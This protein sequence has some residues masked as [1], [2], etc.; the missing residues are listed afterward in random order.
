MINKPRSDSAA[1]MV[2]RLR[3]LTR[4]NVARTA[5]LE[6]SFEER[7]RIFD[8]LSDCVFV[9]AGG[10]FLL[11]NREGT[12]VLESVGNPKGIL[13]DLRNA[14]PGPTPALSDWTRAIDRRGDPLVLRVRSTLPIR[15]R[16][17]AGRVVV[18]ENLSG[19][20]RE[21]V[22]N[23]ERTATERRRI[24]RDLHDGI[25]QI[26]TFLSFK[27]RSLEARSRDAAQCANM[28]RIGETAQECAAAAARLVREFDADG[29]RGGESRAKKSSCQ[30]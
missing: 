13:E 21:T 28:G 16:E 27:A 9:F 17:G 10:E 3:A 5:A 23:R 15:L 19:L 20:V 6:R 26:L 4:A 29:M 22:A 18:A 8:A 2:R 12:R 14:R 24:A 7:E 1:A 30:T 11:A 25:S